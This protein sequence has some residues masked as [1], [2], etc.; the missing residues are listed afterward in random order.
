MICENCQHWQQ[1]TEITGRCE[2]DNQLAGFG[3]QLPTNLEE[4]QSIIYAAGKADVSKTPDG[5]LAL[6]IYNTLK[7]RGISDDDIY[8][9]AQALELAN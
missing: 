5:V 7:S 4:A 9:V 2:L 3:I 1:L 8:A 6:S